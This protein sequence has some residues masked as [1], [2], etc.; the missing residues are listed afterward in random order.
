MK[1]NE[2][3][4]TPFEQLEARVAFLEREL[5]RTVVIIDN[6]EMRTDTR[7]KAISEHLDKQ[8]IDQQ[9]FSA[10]VDDRFKQLSASVDQRFEH[11]YGELADIKSDTVEIRNILATLVEKLNK[12][13]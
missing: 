9:K 11:V 4:S 13:S 10:S 7:L 12:P 8:D 6:I 2:G 3:M 5:R 1:S